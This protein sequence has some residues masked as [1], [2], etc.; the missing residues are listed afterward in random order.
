MPC[1]D[2]ELSHTIGVFGQ[3]SAIGMFSGLV[4]SPESSEAAC[5]KRARLAVP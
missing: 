1:A 5:E 2:R 3:R 4:P